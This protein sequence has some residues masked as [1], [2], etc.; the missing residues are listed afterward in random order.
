[1]VYLFKIVILAMLVI[2]RGYIFSWPLGFVVSD[3]LPDFFGTSYAY[4]AFPNFQDTPK[5]YK[6]IRGES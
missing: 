1:M 3:P 6:A 2:T 5:S 4:E